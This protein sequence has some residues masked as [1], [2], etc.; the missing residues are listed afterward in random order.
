LFFINERAPGASEEQVFS[1]GLEQCRLADELG[2]DV[3]WLGE[4]HFSPYGTMPD[5]MVF[6]AAVSQLTK[7]IRIGTAVIVP[8]FQHPI[9]VAEQVA[10][11]DLLSG[12]RFWLGVGRGYQQREFKGF[13]ISQNESKSRFRESVTIIE[14]LLR[15]PTFTYEGEFWRVNDLGI[16]PRPDRDIPIYVAV[17][18]T[19]ESFDW[20]VEKNFGVLVGNPYSI[21]SGNE[22]AQEMYSAAQRAAGKQESGENAWGTLNNVFVHENSQSAKDIFE[23][24][25]AVGNEYLWKYA[26]VVEEGEEIPD[27][28]KHYAGW[29]DMIHTQEYKSIWDS[30]STL[31]G[32]PEEIVDRLGN[33][34][35]LS[36]TIDKFILWMNRGGS[37]PQKDV[38]KSLE[39]FATEVMPKFHEPVR[40]GKS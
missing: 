30:P 39:L 16:T 23:K 12:G 1:E 8:T 22:G 14:G 4:H 10:M 31:V 2:Y 15:N 5:T 11:L 40:A 20:A 19:P 27:D 29:K 13:G 37:I 25:W 35:E 33:L 9:R 36:G 24:T 7:D 34:A 32:S 18:R 26:R 38:M 6:A 21:D 3:L 28:Y 17:S